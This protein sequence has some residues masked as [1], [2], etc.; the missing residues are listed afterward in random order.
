MACASLEW[1]EACM[2]RCMA[3]M[4]PCCTAPHRARAIFLLAGASAMGCGHAPGAQYDRI[5]GEVPVGTLG[6]PE[7]AGDAQSV[8]EDAQN[9]SSEMDSSKDVVVEAQGDSPQEGSVDGSLEMPTDPDL[10]SPVWSMVKVGDPL[11]EPVDPH[12]FAG[13][14]GTK[15][16]FSA[17]IAFLNQLTP[18]HHWDQLLSAGPAGGERGPYNQELGPLLA[19]AGVV[20]KRLFT[21][22]DFGAPSGIYLLFV[23]LP[24][25]DAPPVV[26]DD[27]SIGAGLPLGIDRYSPDGA[28]MVPWSVLYRNELPWDTANPVR[29]PVAGR[30]TGPPSLTHLPIAMRVNASYGFHDA[31][32]PR[33]DYEW[34]VSLRMPAHDPQYNQE[35]WDLTARF[36]VR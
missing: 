20:E 15:D 6:A 17:G 1:R 34:Q 24:S 26:L 12:W 31:S 28:G 4:T 27:G 22:A 18:F 32:D 5:T 23:L 13:P 29:L 21:A 10:S 8:F 19:R 30:P 25:E 3:S 16:D 9:T 36:W 33:G 14:L 35:G 7:D 2:V 11:W